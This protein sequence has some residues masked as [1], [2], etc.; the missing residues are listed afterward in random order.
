MFIHVYRGLG[1]FLTKAES[2]AKNW[3]CEGIN[4]IDPCWPYTWKITLVTWQ[5][6]QALNG[7]SPTGL[8]RLTVQLGCAPSR[9]P[10]I[11]GSKQCTWVFLLILAD[12]KLPKT[13]H[14]EN[15]IFIGAKCEKGW[16]LDLSILMNNPKSWNNLQ[17]IDPPNW[18][19]QKKLAW[20]YP[21]YNDHTK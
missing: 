5:L 10:A 9:L 18:M 20:T 6:V 21:Q 3:T 8:D 7:T 17:V 19:I 15:L 16:N 12:Q 14:Q 13:G 1:Y 11:I 2:P 4:K